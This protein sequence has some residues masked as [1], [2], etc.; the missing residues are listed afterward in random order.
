MFCV[1]LCLVRCHKKAFE[2]AISLKRYIFM[3]CGV[4]VFTGLIAAY[5]KLLIAA[6][7][8]TIIAVAEIRSFPLCKTLLEYCVLAMTKVHRDTYE[9]QCAI[10]FIS[11]SI[12][13]ILYIY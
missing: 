6:E 11:V 1:A 13:Y 8:I 5:L 10:C 9:K 7:P 4:V 12:H 2:V 3:A